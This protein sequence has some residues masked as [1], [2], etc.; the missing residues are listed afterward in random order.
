MTKFLNLRIQADAQDTSREHFFPLLHCHTTEWLPLCT[1]MIA[2]K[3]DAASLN[4][5]KAHVGRDTDQFYQDSQEVLL[6][7]NRNTTN[8]DTT[9]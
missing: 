9:I 4:S 2:S 8:G 1:V 7:D 5:T 3:M 6:A